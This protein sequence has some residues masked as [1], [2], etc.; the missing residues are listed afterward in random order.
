MFWV[1]FC[2]FLGACL[3]AGATGGLF[4]P[5]PWYRSLQ[6]PWFTPPDW[7]FPVT[8]FVLY[9]CMSVAGARAALTEGNHYAMAFWALQ[10]ALNGLWTPVFFGL[11]DIRMGM[12]VI[13]LLWVSVL[14]GLVAL[15]QVDVLAGVLF[16]PYLIWV[17][18]AAALNAGVWRLNP[19]AARNPPPRPS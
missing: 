17:S 4:P 12:A 14:C 15:W 7:V 16:V 19:D 2:L 10:I 13:V 11:K 3:G 18:I 9:F 6:K 5:G 8:W 1:L